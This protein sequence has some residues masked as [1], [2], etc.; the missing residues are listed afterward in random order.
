MIKM[1]VT[2]MSLLCFFIV[3]TTLSIYVIISDYDM[4]KKKLQDRDL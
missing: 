4:I 3:K 2:E 1:S